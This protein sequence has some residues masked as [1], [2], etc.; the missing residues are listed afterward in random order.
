[1]LEA[2]LEGKPIVCFDSG[3]APEFVR[4]D[5][6]FVIP[7]FDVTGMAEKIS[8]LLS[9]SEL[10]I[11]MGQV[12]KARVLN[13]HSLETCA[14]RIAAIIQDVVHTPLPVVNS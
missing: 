3:G 11:Q 4:A 7:R 5:A 12:A 14:P 1:M 8:L 9:S 13:Q 6:G 10:R 2:A